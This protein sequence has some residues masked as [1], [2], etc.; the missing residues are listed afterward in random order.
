M[1]KPTLT[2]NLKKPVS[3]LNLVRQFCEGKDVL[4]V[5]CV[6][7]DIENTDGS[8]W[9]HSTIV[10]VAASVL[11]VDYLERE[12]NELA[13]RGYRVIA[14]DVTKPLEI[15]TQF[16]VIVVGNLIEHLTNFEGLM[17]NIGRLLKP[18]GIA[19]IS[20]ANP[21]FREQYFY[22]AFKNDIIVNAEH[23]CWIDPVTLDQLAQRFEL[24]TSE[25][26]WI[27]EKW[28]LSQVILQDDSR[29]LD[30]FTGKWNFYGTPSILERAIAP[31]LGYVFKAVAPSRFYKRVLE[32]GAQATPRLLYLQIMGS[33]FGVFWVIYRMCVVTSP[34]NKYEL[35][36]SVLKRKS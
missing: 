28:K 10:E 17:L 31:F 14:S 6:N 29:S 35:F 25:V 7:H 33:L 21:F 27:K 4:D 12:I 23:T 18:G 26:H 19:L 20:T 2:Q 13:K 32:Y 9:L 16:D 36:V 3:R 24:F 22:S 8:N 11:G 1:N 5:G 15:D 30:I 34:I